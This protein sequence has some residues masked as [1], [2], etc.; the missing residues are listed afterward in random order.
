MKKQVNFFKIVFGFIIFL[1]ISISLY[2]SYSEYKTKEVHA[3]IMEKRLS[4][5]YYEKNSS[6]DLVVENSINSLKYNSN[7]HK[8]KLIYDFIIYVLI[9]VLF[10][11]RRFIRKFN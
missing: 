10:L 6:I 8:Q 1:G 11:I 9:V 7:Y 4:R 3:S 5:G 2:S